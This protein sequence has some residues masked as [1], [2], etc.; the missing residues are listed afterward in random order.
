MHESASA[1][2][3]DTVPANA[4]V[5]FP[6]PFVY[7]IGVAAGWLLG[8]WIAW[9]ITVGPSRTRDALAVVF[10]LVYLA[11]FV[12][13][14]TAFRSART[15]L[16]PNRAATAFVTRGPYVFTRNP[17]YLSL[18]ALYVAVALWLNS[19]WVLV[20]L[21]VVVLVIDRAVIAREERYLATAFPAEYSAYRSRVRRWL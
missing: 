9:P 5:R 3:N 16:I 11:V 21:P 4:G 20:L 7:V 2:P 6:P 15:T 1:A 8:R 14:F 19:W 13:A 17:M 12:G 18:V 10:A